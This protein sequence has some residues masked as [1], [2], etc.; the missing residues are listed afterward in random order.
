MK[1]WKNSSRL[2]VV[3]FNVRRGLAVFLRLP[4][5]LGMIFDLAGGDAFSPLSFL[6]EHIAPH[7]A[8]YNQS[9]P[10]AQLIVSHPHADHIS[11][12]ALFN[13]SRNGLNAGLITLPHDRTPEGAADESVDFSRIQNDDNVKLIKAYKELYEGRNPPLQTID[14]AAC[15]SGSFDLDYGIYYMRP[16]HVSK[17]HPAD[18]HA[19]GNGLSLCVFIRYGDQTM[20]LTGDV[21]PEVHKE[22]LN[23]GTSIERRFT[24]FVS[25]S[26]YAEESSRVSTSSQPTPAEL[27]QRYGLDVLVAPHHGLK[28]GFSEEL[29][30]CIRGNRTLVNVISEKRHQNSGDGQVDGRYSSRNYAYGTDVDIE[31]EK[32][33]RMQ[34]TTRN[35]HHLLISMGTDLSRPK[36]YMRK[37]PAD[38]LSLK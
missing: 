4:N 1:Q 5:N 6:K 35:S 23:G 38:L 15:P 24:S 2:Q 21:T 34:V 32:F 9:Q 33:R 3:V 16:P 19:Y 25:G 28:S 20:W 22:M 17:L 37:N 14:P 12:A 30:Q 13:N 7:L 8:K 18:D 29:F 27:F 11:E 10:I 36:V 26:E 31:G